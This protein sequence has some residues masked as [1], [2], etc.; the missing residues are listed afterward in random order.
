MTLGYFCIMKQV[1]V[2]GTEE[3]VP[4]HQ[5]QGSSINECGNSDFILYSTVSASTESDILRR[6]FSPPWQYRAVQE[7]PPR[8]PLVFSHK[9]HQK[10]FT[11]D[12]NNIDDLIRFWE[13]GAY[14]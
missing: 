5:L 12:Q 1:L 6:P 8:L 10:A 4:W 13:Q 9:Q 14:Y 3:R 7:L 11:Y 2:E